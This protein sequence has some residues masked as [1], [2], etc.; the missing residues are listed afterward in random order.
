MSKYTAVKRLKDNAES[1]SVRWI[2]KD[3]GIPY[4][5]LYAAITIEGR[6]SLSENELILLDHCL[7]QL[8]KRI[9]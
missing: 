5:R 4:H 3:T 9:K 1:L 7:S 6:E 2:A 8:G